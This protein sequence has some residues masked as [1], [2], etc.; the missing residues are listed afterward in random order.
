MVDAT[1]SRGGTSVDIPLQKEGG[2]ILVSSTFGKPEAKIR[3]SGGTLN[4]QVTDEWSGIQTFQLKGTLYDYATTHDLADLIKSASATPLTLE[5]PGDV[6]PDSLTVCA[7]AGQDSALSLVY[8]AGKRD[9]VDVNLSLTRVGEANAAQEQQAS[10]PTAIG[11][12]PV[13]VTVGGTTVDL[14]TADLSL[15]RT[16]GRPNDVVRRQPSTS[17]PR[18]VAKA[19]VTSDVFTFSFETIQ[20]IPATLNAI[21][22]NIFRSRLGR[23]GVSVDFN[24]LLGLG[25]IQAIPVGSSP[26]RQVH[27][28]GKG[29][30]TSP[31]LEFRR[32]LDTS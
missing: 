23:T 25:Q 10:T 16:V 5:L 27:Q 14:P 15:E 2:E 19:K 20:N 18:Y 21:T 28:A 3:D 1:L 32:I 17:D 31:V 30:V 24:G 7:A 9:M 13:Q 8:P 4:P 12:G 22:D 11:T 29:W 26:F 6:Y